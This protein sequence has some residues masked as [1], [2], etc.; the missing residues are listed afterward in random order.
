MVGEARRRGPAGRDERE[1]HRAE[2]AKLLE[3]MVE[4]GMV[5]SITDTRRITTWRVKGLRN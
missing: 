5:E 4:Q 1:L 2:I 3:E